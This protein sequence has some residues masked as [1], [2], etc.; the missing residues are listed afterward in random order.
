MPGLTLT[1]TTHA[2]VYN[3]FTLITAKTGYSQAKVNCREVTLVG[4]PANAA[5][6]VF[7]G[8]ADVSSSN[9]GQQ[10]IAAQ[11]TTMRS[12]EI[13]GISLADVWLTSD[14]DAAKVDV[15]WDYV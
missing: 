11:S 6:K 15:D 12:R 8:G 1:L 10:L 13:N 5:A 3:L 9:F 4:D 14:T 2:T 7:K